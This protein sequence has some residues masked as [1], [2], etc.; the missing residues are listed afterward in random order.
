MTQKVYAVLEQSPCGDY[1][2]LV[3]IYSSQKIAEDVRRQFAFPN[4][5]LIDEYPLRD[6]PKL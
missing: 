6:T 1:E 2:R 3:G 5:I 4:R